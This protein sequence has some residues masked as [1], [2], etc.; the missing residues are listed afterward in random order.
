MSSFSNFSRSQSGSMTAEEFHSALQEATNYSLK[1]F[2]L[3]HL[4]QQLPSLQRDLSNAA[5]ASNQV[6]SVVA[7][8]CETCQKL[9]ANFYDRGIGLKRYL[10]RIVQTFS[11]N[12]KQRC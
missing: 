12:N 10:K 6:S 11:L 9:I 5:R 1:G 3:P 4:K 8:F 7:H 2:V